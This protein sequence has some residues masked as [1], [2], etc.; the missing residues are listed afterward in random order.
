MAPC[1]FFARGLCR[2]GDSCKFSHERGLGINALSPH[3]TPPCHFF[4][5]GLCKAGDSC[6]FSHD[7]DTDDG[8]V[9]RFSEYSLQPYFP[10][11][12]QSDAEEKPTE[13]CKFFLLGSCKRSD[14]CWY[15]HELQIRPDETSPGSTPGQ[16][17]ENTQNPS[18]PRAVILCKFLFFPS[19]CQKDPCP[20]LHPAGGEGVDLTTARLR[21]LKPNDEVDPFP[22]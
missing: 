20:Y 10:A 12:E 18:D 21:E 1:H 13:I 14:N 6:K 11:T 15:R 17:D 7:D 22:S 3:Q 5:R 2:A 16:H 8:S 4:A 19:G 9:S